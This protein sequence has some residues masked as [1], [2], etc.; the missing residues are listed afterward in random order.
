MVEEEDFKFSCLV[1]CCEN[2]A[3][4][5]FLGFVHGEAVAADDASGALDGNEAGEDA[6]IEIAQ[7]QFD[8]LGVIPAEALLPEACLFV[9]QRAQVAADEQT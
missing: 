2:I 9:E 5:G 4:N 1:P 8:G 6:G 3:D 7:E